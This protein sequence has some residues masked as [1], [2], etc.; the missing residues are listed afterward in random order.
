MDPQTIAAIGVVLF[1]IS[2]LI[3]MSRLKDNSVIQLVLRVLIYLF[4]R[5]TKK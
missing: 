2:E 4:P 5:P 3:G 1:C